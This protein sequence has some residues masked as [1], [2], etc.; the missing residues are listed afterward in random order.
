MGSAVSIFANNFGN[1]IHFF[2]TFM[3]LYPYDKAERIYIY[4]NEIMLLND[5]FL[6]RAND[7]KYNRLVKF[8]YVPRNIKDI[9]NVISYQS[10]DH[11]VVSPLTIFTDDDGENKLFRYVIIFSSLELVMP[12]RCLT[13][14]AVKG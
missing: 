10:F 9:L 8:D 13:C 12:A 14:S 1:K 6:I 3:C 4:N 2:E 7:I 11:N 5:I